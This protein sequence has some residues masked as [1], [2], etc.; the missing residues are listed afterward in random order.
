MEMPVPEA[1][2][3]AYNRMKYELENRDKA[4]MT[5]QAFGFLKRGPMCGRP[6][7]RASRR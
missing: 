7:S 2:P 1:D 3:V 6:P 5:S 4:G